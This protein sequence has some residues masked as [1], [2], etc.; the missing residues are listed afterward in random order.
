MWPAF[1]NRSK[2]RAMLLRVPPEVESAPPI[3]KLKVYNALY[4]KQMLAIR[5]R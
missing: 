2:D 4:A 3:D 1:H 5:S